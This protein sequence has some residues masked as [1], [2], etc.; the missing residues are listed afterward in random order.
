MYN[1]DQILTLYLNESPYGGRRNG[2]ESG[3]QTY[4]GK[5]AKDLTISEAALL[6]SIPQNPSLYDP[7]NTFGNEYLIARQQHVIDNMVDLKMITKE[8]GENAKKDPVLDK[9]KPLSSQYAGVK[10]PH[11]IQMVKA[12]LQD[13][14]GTSVLGKGGMKITTTLDLRIQDKLN[15]AIAD[16]FNS[17]TPARAG[18]TNAAST[19]E[20]VKTG[21]IVALA[22]SR[23]FSYEGFGQDNAAT[24]YIQPGSSI[25]PF[26]YSELFSQKPAGELNYGSGSILKDE[27]IDS[28]Y[29]AKVNNA[30]RTFK[31][32]L[33][34]R[35]SLGGSRNIPAIKAMY[36]SGIQNTLSTIHAMGVTSYCTQGNDT[37]VGLSAAIGSCG[38]RQIDLVNGYTTIARGGVWMKQSTI[39]EAKNSNGESLMQWQAE[40]KRVIDNQA[41]Y[42]VS[43]ILHD[44]AARAT[45]VSS[46]TKGQSIAGVPTGTKT[47]TSD[48]GGQSKDIW[49]MSYSPVLAMGVWFGNNDT[50]ILKSGVSSMPGPIVEAVMSYAHKEIYAKDGRWKLNDWLTAP[51]GIQRVGNEVYPSWWSANQGQTDQELI[52]DKFS[53]KK[54]TQCTPEAAKITIKV[55]KSIDPV[56]KKDVYIAPDGYDGNSDDD[57]HQCSD[58]PPSSVSVSTTRITSSQYRINVSVDKGTFD[59]S[60]VDIK[61][62][63]QIVSTITAGST[64]SYVYNIP[65]TASG[66]LDISAVATDVAYYQGTSNVVSINAP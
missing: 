36:I 45:L 26:V 24:A 44:P 7:Y 9:I 29:G 19:V 43:D 46:T 57:K 50:R 35:L 51:A 52:M 66:S 53:K 2:V 33:T 10:A 3:A 22:G 12:E 42:V 61:V 40:S 21:Q 38:V 6:A 13:K 34:I 25:K 20:D 55:K 16:M 31:G 47:G 4:F 58:T 39:I 8:D 59:I 37:Q 28:L 1:K 41:T 48:I 63:G 5:S 60:Q 65:T 64:Y 62:D 23:D 17:P 15:Q 54:A 30:D 56:T 11:F 32:D 27:N 14:L 18:F 49:M